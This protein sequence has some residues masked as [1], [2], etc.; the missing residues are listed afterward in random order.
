MTKRHCE[1]TTSSA[2]SGR[3]DDRLRARRNPFL[4]VAGL[5]R[6]ASL[7]MTKKLPDFAGAQSGLQIVER[8]ERTNV[9]RHGNPSQDFRAPPNRRTKPWTSEHFTGRRAG[10]TAVQPGGARR[11]RAFICP[12]RSATRPARAYVVPGGIEA[13]TVAPWRISARCCCAHGLTFDDVF[14]CTV[15]LADMAEL[16]SLQQ[17]LRHLFQTRPAAGAAPPS[18]PT[19]WRAAPRRGTQMRRL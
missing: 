14:K 10:Q 12:A 11:R 18:A 15:M 3:P 8:T 13:K 16:G 4:A 5:L 7:A 9:P 6:F 1:E 2:E 19:G 17:N